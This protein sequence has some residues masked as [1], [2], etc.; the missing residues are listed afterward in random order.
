MSL[1]VYVFVVV[2]GMYT[3]KTGNFL[4]RAFKF[5]FVLVVFELNVFNL[6]FSL[7][8]MGC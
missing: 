3:C 8:L 6:I 4:K 7:H 2:E 5:M 1:C